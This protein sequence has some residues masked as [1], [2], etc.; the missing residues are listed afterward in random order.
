MCAFTVYVLWKACMPTCLYMHVQVDDKDQHKWFAYS[1]STLF[2][3]TGSPT[4][5]LGSG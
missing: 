5:P 2:F 3:A 4:E 1:L